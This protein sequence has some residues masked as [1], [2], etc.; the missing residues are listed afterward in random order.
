MFFVC[1]ATSEIIWFLQ[2]DVAMDESSKSYSKLL[3]VQSSKPRKFLILKSKFGHRKENRCVFETLRA[4]IQYQIFNSIQR[5][6][7]FKNYL[8]SITRGGRISIKQ[9]CCWQMEGW[10]AKWLS[11]S[12]PMRFKMPADPANQRSP[13]GSR[14]CFHHPGLT[15]CNGLVLLPYYGVHNILCF[16]CEVEVGTVCWRHEK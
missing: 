12:R 10:T 2:A 14:D 7:H 1:F 8:S 3:I 16:M 15:S 9:L 13:T 5:D 4:G 11:G 6:L